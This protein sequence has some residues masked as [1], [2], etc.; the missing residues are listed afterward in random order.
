MNEGHEQRWRRHL[1][2]AYVHLRELEES[3]DVDAA[4]KHV[5]DETRN[6]DL[7]SLLIQQFI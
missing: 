2:R 7:K 6:R 3:V 5:H 4:V 1:L